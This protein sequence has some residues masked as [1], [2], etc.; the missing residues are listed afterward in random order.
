M[1][2]DTNL[3]HHIPYPG[4]QRSSQTI[5]LRRLSQTAA[6]SGLRLV[7]L[8]KWAEAQSNT[9]IHPG[10][11]RRLARIAARDALAALTVQDD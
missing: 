8:I 1:A 11:I 10:E 5:R 3:P 7:Q 4:V 6:E 2:Y 9:Y